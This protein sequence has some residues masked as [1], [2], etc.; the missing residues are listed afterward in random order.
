M[1]WDTP[2]RNIPYL[3]KMLGERDV[4]RPCYAQHLRQPRTQRVLPGKNAQ[5]H[6]RGS[7]TRC[8]LRGSRTRHHP[9]HQTKRSCAMLL[10]HIHIRNT[11]LHAATRATHRL[12]KTRRHNARFKTA[13]KRG[14]RRIARRKGRN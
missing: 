7:R 3:A 11:L 10:T 2:K 4:L 1:P 5:H 12:R 8:H 14:I 6:L 13:H 9:R